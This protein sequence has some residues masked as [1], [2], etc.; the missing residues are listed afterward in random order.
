[1]PQLTSGVSDVKGNK[2]KP[3]PPLPKRIRAKFSAAHK[4]RTRTSEHNAKIGASRR[5]KHSM[6]NEQKV[7]VALQYASGVPARVLAERHGFGVSYPRRLYL[8]FM[9][10]VRNYT[11]SSED[12]QI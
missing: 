7:R 2:F 12:E 10:G 4:K 6:S 9:T 3:R 1:M 8:A 5:G 11:A